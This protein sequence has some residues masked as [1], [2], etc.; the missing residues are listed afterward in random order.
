MIYFVILIMFI[1]KYK[2]YAKA[3]VEQSTHYPKF[4]GLNPASTSDS[5]KGET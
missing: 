3:V 4:K 1:K 5:G 2:Y